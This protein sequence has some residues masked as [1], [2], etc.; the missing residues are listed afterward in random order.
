MPLKLPR[1][2][3]VMSPD[4]VYNYTGLLTGAQMI[5]GDTLNQIKKA[6]GL[7]FGSRLT[8]VVLYGSEARGQSGPE[9]DI[10]LLVLLKGPI[11]YG[12]DLQRCIDAVYDFSAALGRRISAKPADA[13][14]YETLDCPLY[15]AAH[16]EGVAA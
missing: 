5:P 1:L 4:S 7:A 10:D 11:D 16:E 14:E 15:R 9:S 12:Q 13:L 3:L 2:R 6:L 8:G